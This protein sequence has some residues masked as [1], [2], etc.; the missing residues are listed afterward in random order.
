MRPPVADAA[1]RCSALSW[2]RRNAIRLSPLWLTTRTLGRSHACDVRSSA[3]RREQETVRGHV[4]HCASGVVHSRLHARTRHVGRGLI[5]V[6][7]PDVQLLPPFVPATL[8][9][10]MCILSSETDAHRRAADH[11]C[12][13]P[14]SIGYTGRPTARRAIGLA[15]LSVWGLAGAPTGRLPTSALSP[16]SYP[17]TAALRHRTSYPTRATPHGS[18]PSAQW[19]GRQVL[20]PPIR[21]PLPAALRHP[22]SHPTRC[23]PARIASQGAMVGPSPIRTQPCAC[24]CVCVRVRVLAC[25]CARVCV[26]MCMCV[27]ARVRACR[28]VR[29]R[30]C[31]CVCVRVCVRAGEGTPCCAFSCFG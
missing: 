9:F 25:A 17:P 21:T 6:R 27:R 14:R 31:A 7:S 26:R 29:A 30:A 5:D 10:V 19:S 23:C 24:V 18:H 11:S 8:S 13:S 3:R 15:G 4:A 1:R 22:T 16:N 2:P 20:S 12:S 28:P